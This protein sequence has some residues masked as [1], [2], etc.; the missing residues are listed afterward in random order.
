MAGAIGGVLAIVFFVTAH[1]LGHF[2]AAKM[3]GVKATEFFFGFGPRIWSFKRG[4]TEYGIK[5]I[6]LGGYV[7]IVGMNPLE[8]VPESDLGR[9]YREQPF[10][11]KAVVVLAGVGMNFLIAYLMFAAL[12]MFN[13]VSELT[14]TLAGVVPTL[15]DGITP[16]PAA[17]AGLEAGDR[18]L[19]IDGVPTPDWTAVGE[20]LSSRPEE[21][22]VLTVQ[23]GDEVL[24]LTA[25]LATRTDPETGEVGGFLGIGPTVEVRKLSLWEAIGS[26][27][28]QLGSS[29]VVTFQVLGQIVQP[30]TLGRLAGVLV[31]N[32]DVP[33]EFRPVSPIGVA[34]IGSQVEDIGWGSFLFLL[35]SVNVMLAALNVLPLYPLDGGH[36]A[37]ALYEK[38]TRRAVNVRVLIPVAAVVITLVGF[39]GLIAII[40]DLV[41]P[42]DL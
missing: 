8:E 10:W 15:D 4:E 41:N 20:E 30:G 19:A 27:G 40:L 1:E 13:G 2:L 37:V 35:A 38:I 16:T 31:G 11:K 6:P 25:T 17:D 32:T 34:N 21:R 18:V 5:A 29:V 14:T 36:F 33:L 12:L 39:L 26:A 9:T 7:R 28:Q 23:R 24:E 42:I 3:V 22:I